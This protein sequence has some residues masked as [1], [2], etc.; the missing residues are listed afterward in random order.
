MNI[1]TVTKV[2]LLRFTLLKANLSIIY[3]LPQFGIAAYLLNALFKL[4]L[5]AGI[6]QIILNKFS[7]V[8]SIQYPGDGRLLIR[9][10][11]S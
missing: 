11:D 9:K 3:I 7:G 5:C 8:A 1:V 10:P 4:Q 6:G 2:I